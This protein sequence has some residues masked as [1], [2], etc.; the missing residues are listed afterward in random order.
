MLEWGLE[1]VFSPTTR[2]CV[3]PQHPVSSSLF[4]VQHRII[5]VII[6]IIISSSSTMKK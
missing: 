1:V 2:G 4:M 3:S 6:I 5:I